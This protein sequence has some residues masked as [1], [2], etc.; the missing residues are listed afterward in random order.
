[1]FSPCFWILFIRGPL[2]REK[3][4]LNSCLDRIMWLFFRHNPTVLSEE[5]E[6]QSHECVIGAKVNTR[7][8]VVDNSSVKFLGAAVGRRR[9]QMVEIDTRQLRRDDGA[10][11]P[12]KMHIC[13]FPLL[14]TLK[15]NILVIFQCRCIISRLWISEPYTNLH[16]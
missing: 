16:V 8:R 6:I 4:F 13:A 11:H 7:C 1:M 12:R 9:N 15:K 14:A 2:S 3:P 5:Y 10:S